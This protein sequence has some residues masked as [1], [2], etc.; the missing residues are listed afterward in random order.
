M[1]SLETKE[2]IKSRFY[3]QKNYFKA[4]PLTQPVDRK[5]KIS[6]D[7]KII[8]PILSLRYKCLSCGDCTKRKL[9]PSKFLKKCTNCKNSSHLTQLKPS[10]SILYAS[11]HCQRIS[12]NQ[13]WVDKLNFKNIIMGTPYCKN[14]SRRKKIFSIIYKDVK[15][16]FK[17]YFLFKCSYCAK[18]KSLTLPDKIKAN[19]N[20]RRNIINQPTCLECN[21][22]MTFVKNSRSIFSQKIKKS[23]QSI[24]ATIGQDKTQQSKNF[25]SNRQMQSLPNDKK[26]NR[27][28]HFSKG[29]AAFRGRN[30]PISK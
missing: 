22:L 24:K 7:E 3:S 23:A 21:S 20:A 14:C 26:Y 5:N 12:C 2:K 27:K 16:S 10:F 11:Y 15:I 28:V 29:G 6:S 19:L 4:K 9:H 17:N 13:K 30:R 8:S 1:S 18:V 25:K